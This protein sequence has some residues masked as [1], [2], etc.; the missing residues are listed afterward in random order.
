MHRRLLLDN[1]SWLLPGVS[2]ARTLAWGTVAGLALAAL[3]WSPLSPVALDRGDVLYGGG[4]VS[5]AVHH[6]ELVGQYHPFA[7]TRIEA[8]RRAATLAATDLGSP[9]Q[10]RM[11]L[12]RVIEE[13]ATPADVKAQAWEQL[14]H[15]QWT[16]FDA[17]DEA[18]AAFQMAYRLDMLGDA[19]PRR[20]VEEARARTE[21]SDVNTALEA[22]DRVFE[23]VPDHRALARV[24]QASLLLSASDVM[25]ALDAY[26]EALELTDDP[27][28]QQV[29]RLGTAA[30]KERLGELDGAVADIDAAGLP[31]AVRTE[32]LR[33]LEERNGSL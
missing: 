16:S 14:G 3:W 10:A 11:F 33:R 19:A 29:A 15:L 18:A 13:P 27:A 23:R 8:N 1:G 32:R 24:S 28:L 9:A 31:D 26:T 2:R 4:D 25:G 20:L 7:T 12:Q 21:S 22:W 5:T 30:C 17:P 6:Y